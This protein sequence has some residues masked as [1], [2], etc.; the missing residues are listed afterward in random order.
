MEPLYNEESGTYEVK[1]LTYSPTAG[2]L[3]FSIIY[4]SLAPRS[5]A[6]DLN[7]Q[8]PCPEDPSLCL[9]LMDGAA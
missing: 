8:G 4:P 2:T 7:P 1:S 6:T 3:N 5:S 9:L